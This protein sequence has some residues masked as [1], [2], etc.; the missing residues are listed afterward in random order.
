M[1][2][3][4]INISLNSNGGVSFTNEEQASLIVKRGDIVNWIFP[5]GQNIKIDSSKYEP[6][7]FKIKSWEFPVS[8]VILN[9]D[10]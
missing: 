6:L 8:A 4:T 1:A 10:L 5:G 7:P 3:H 2:I 9:R